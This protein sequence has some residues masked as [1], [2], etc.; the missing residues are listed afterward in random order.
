MIKKKRTFS[1]NHHKSYKYLLLI[2]VAILIGL[3][4]AIYNLRTVN[5]NGKD[6]LT[7]AVTQAN[8]DI[9]LVQ[10][11]PANNEIVVL[12]LPGSTQINAA[13]NLGSWKLKSIWELGV[14]EKLEGTLLTE[15]ITHSYK[16]P[17]TYWLSDKENKFDFLDPKL[18]NI[19]RII[20]SSI[21]SNLPSGDRLRIYLFALRT[22]SYKRIREDVAEYP[23]LKNE[24]L[25]DGE[26]G[27]VLTGNTSQKLFSYF[28]DPD[29]VEQAIT[30]SIVDGSGRGGVA[31]LLGDLMEVLGA[32]IASIKSI[33][34]NDLDCLVSGNNPRIVAKISKLLGCEVKDAEDSAIDVT[35]EFGK[36]FADRY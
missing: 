10:L 13:R 16:F 21:N 32:K 7:V 20:G 25:T 30:I 1:N 9:Q 23:Y 27:Y 35:I 11:R 17:V 22:K 26:K 33:P 31:K 36:I 14:N 15:S 3:T 19:S 6:P 4:L 12:V 24:I 2:L 18:I 5:W 28:A 34:V 29:I 8:G